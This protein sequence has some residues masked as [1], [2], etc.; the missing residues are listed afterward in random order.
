M[1]FCYTVYAVYL[2]I[3][4]FGELECKCKLVDIL[5]GKE[6]DIDVDYLN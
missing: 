5:F 3:I 4:K 1:N 6:D 2:A